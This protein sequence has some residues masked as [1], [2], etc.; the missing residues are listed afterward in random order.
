MAPG[1]GV[2]V[3]VRQW[4]GAVRMTVRSSTWKRGKRESHIEQDHVLDLPADISVISP[5]FVVQAISDALVELSWRWGD[6]GQYP[7]F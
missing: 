4:T 3:T 1:D 5:D 7:L 6:P 2:T